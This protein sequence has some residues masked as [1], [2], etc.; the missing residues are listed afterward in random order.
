MSSTLFTASR[1]T[2]PSRMIVALLS[3]TIT[4][5]LATGCNRGASPLA[6]SSPTPSSLDLTGAVTDNGASQPVPNAH[7]DI[8]DGANQGKSATADAN[9]RYDLADLQP[10][11]FSVRAQADGFEATAQAVTLTDNRTVNFALRRAAKDAG[12]DAGS[13]PTKFT[14]SGSVKDNDTQS[15][16]ANAHVEIVD[17]AN[18]G[19]NA[20]VGASGDASGRYAIASLDAGSFVLR[21]WADGYDYRQQTVTV[22]PNQSVDFTLARSAAAAPP[23][24]TPAA[25]TGPAATGRTVDVLSNRPLAGMT[26]RI[27]GVGEGTTGADGMFSI[28]GANQQQTRV[29]TVASPNTVERQTRIRV[30]GDA[31]TL[32]LIPKEINLGAFDEMFRGGGALR[33]WVHAPRLVVERRVLAYSGQSNDT[34]VATADLMSDADAQALVADLTWA[35][36]QLTGGTY[37]SFASVSIEAANEG[38]SVAVTR[39]DEIVVARYKGLT[40]ATSYWGYSRWAW[41]ET[42]AIVAGVMMLDSDFETSSS[43]FHRSLR[44]HELGHALGYN[45]VTASESVM[46]SAARTEPNTFDRDASTVA[47]RRAPLNMSPDIDPDPV[48]VSRARTGQIRWNGAH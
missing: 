35:L 18:K 1:E 16:I 43:P 20:V 27:D 4:A 45:H 13:A 5:T 28:A 19:K 14:V 40:S 15:A 11:T 8:V 24:T 47:F 26:V 23:T 34:Y 2:L 38:D 21:A 25:P 44:A 37:G 6:P 12:K 3:L 30:P 33:R 32:T 22:G 36:P 39:I 29:V 9:G 17:G 42:G 7:I 46:T 31:A 48:T 10:G 41:D